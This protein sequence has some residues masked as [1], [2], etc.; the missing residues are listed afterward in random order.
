LTVD[1]SRPLPNLLCRLAASQCASM[2]GLPFGFHSA[3]VSR[4]T[5]LLYFRNR[6][7][8]RNAGQWLS[9][10]A[11]GS[12]DSPNRYA[13]NAFDSVNKWDPLGLESSGAAGPQRQVNFD[14]VE[15]EGNKVTPGLQSPAPPRPDFP[16]AG[17]PPATPPPSLATAPLATPFDRLGLRSE[18]PGATSTPTLP[19]AT[20]GT[21]QPSANPSGNTPRPPATEPPS[22]D[23]D[24]ITFE[25]AIKNGRFKAY[26]KSIGLSCE[27]QTPTYES[28]FL[29]IGLAS[30]ELLEIVNVGQAVRGVAGAVALVRSAA[31]VVKAARAA[32]AAAGAT[33]KITSGSQ[34]TEEVIRQAMKDAPLK[35]QQAGGVSLPKVQGYV[36]DLLAGKTPPAIKVDGNMI[37]DGNHR[38][39]AGQVLGQPPPVQMWAGGRP[40]SAVPWETIPIDTKAWR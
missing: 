6:W 34:V 27:E 37:L 13:F 2:R 23:P 31:N 11:L 10:D 39:I 24:L 15:I 40:G 14:E 33:E 28:G 30:T 5:G 22:G 38:Y 4:A 36:D 16:Q 8:S 26:C 29:Q 3:Y 32:P 12:V 1:P 25:E 19:G 21:Q 17:T 20:G 18:A 9:H 7:Y 35:S